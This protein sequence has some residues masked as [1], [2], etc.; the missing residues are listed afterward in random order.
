MLAIDRPTLA[1]F[2]LAAACAIPP[3]FAQQKEIGDQWE[4]T[5]EM[6]MQGMN[7]PGMT[8]KVCSP[9]GAEPIPAGTEKD[10]CEAYDVKHSANKVSWKM[11]CS[12]PPST[13]VGE[14]VYK[15]RDAY[16]GTMTVT[17]EGETMQMKLNG[18]RLGECD[19]SETKRQI[20]A[21]EKQ[22]AEGQRMAAEQRAKVCAEGLK[23]M[24]AHVFG[25]QSGF[26]C[27]A[28]QKK[29]FCTKFQGTDGFAQVARQA[30]AP[31]D[32]EVAKAGKLCGVDG[33]AMR[34]KMC[35]TAEANESADFLADACVGQGYGAKMAARECA[36]RGYTSPVAQKYAKF[37]TAYGRRNA[38]QANDD[39]A[40]KPPAAPAKSAT[41]NA[42]DKGKDFIKGLFR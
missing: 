20:A 28:A 24:Q 42:V 32:S 6:S 35:K 16:S 15:G 23:N 21:I 41:E 17:S 19:A 31:G 34:T 3:A 30:S 2:A 5:T 7:M 36:G 4:I 14:M 39:G 40:A 37:C 18:R 25:A 26:E 29:E 10:Q 11:R 9:R 1:L 33:E 27:S 8:Q 13:G 12:N 38:M 22:A